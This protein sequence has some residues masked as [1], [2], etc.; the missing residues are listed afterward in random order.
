MGAS[1]VT[2]PCAG[3]PPLRVAC[4]SPAELKRNVPPLRTP[5]H[6]HHLLTPSSPPPSVVLLYRQQPHMSVSS[7]TPYVPLSRRPEWHDVTPLPQ[8]DPPAPSV[9]VPIAYPNEYRD[10]T[11][12][13]RAVLATGER[14]R[15]VQALAGEVIEMNAAH[16]TAWWLRRRCLECL[17][18]EAQAEGKAGTDGRKKGGGRGGGGGGSII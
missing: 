7:P 4:S 17:V 16:Y 2:P 6:I 1:F 15:R 13:M 3:L 11:A 14:S 18:A 9:V 5:V 10:A 12:Y 8:N